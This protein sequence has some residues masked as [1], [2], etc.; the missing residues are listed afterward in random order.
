MRAISLFSGIGGFDLA[1]ERAGIEVVGMCEIDKHAQEVLRA[2]FAAQIVD[3]V[4]KIGKEQYERKSIDIIVG[5]FPCQDL[6][7]AGKREGLAGKRSGLWYE[8]AR[9]IDELEPGW[10]VIENVPGLLSSNKGHDFAVILQWLVQRGYGVSWRILD[11]KNFG[12]AQQR[13]RVFIVG[14]FGNGNSAKVLFEPTSVHRDFKENEKEG[15]ETPISFTVRTGKEGGGKGYL[16]SDNL[17][18]T[19][20]GQSQYLFSPIVMAS[21]RANA[22]IM[23]N[24]S[25]SLLAS[26]AK[27]IVWQMN[28]ADEVYRECG[29]LS[30]TL[31]A[32]MGTG[33]NN[34]PLV[35]LRRFTPIE[36]ERLQ[37]FPDGWTSNQADTHR[38]KQLGNA[39]A[40]PVVEWI[41]K[42]IVKEV[43]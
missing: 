21:E 11:A 2:H 39:V 5:G 43:V 30:P 32:R 6:S 27:P 35:N 4:K 7:I 41:M 42:R 19:L 24:I 28:H 14:S 22:E 10:V 36:C 3:D 34:I 1:M 33:G 31:Q 25:P 8:F 17:A 38:Y 23:E 18:M 26:D 37:G 16:G 40:V 29:D 20:G 9:V 12:V 13:R 15:E